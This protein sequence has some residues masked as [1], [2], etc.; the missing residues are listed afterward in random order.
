MKVFV[1]EGGGTGPVN[2]KCLEIKRDVS[3][4]PHCATKAAQFSIEKDIRVP[5]FY[6]NSHF[7]MCGIM[8]FVDEELELDAKDGWIKYAMDV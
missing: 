6:Y 5:A 3:H 8:K 7:K 4:V 1:P 2:L